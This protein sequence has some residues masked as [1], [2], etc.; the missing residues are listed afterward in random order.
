MIK[1]LPP[2][3]YN[4]LSKDIHL[5]KFIIIIKSIDFVNHSER[6][7]GKPWRNSC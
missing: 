6:D 2:K 1:Q 5:I 4:Y 3:I 7:L